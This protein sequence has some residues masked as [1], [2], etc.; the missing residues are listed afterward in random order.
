MEQCT[1]SNTTPLRINVS[2]GDRIPSRDAASSFGNAIALSKDGLRLVVGAPYA[3]NSRG[4]LNGVVRVYERTGNNWTQVGSDL[5][6]ETSIDWLGS[7]V[8]I[9]D[10]GELVIASAP[11]SS[12]KRGYVK[13]W[14]QD[15]SDWKQFGSDI[16]NESKPAFSSDRFGH[17]IS[18]SR[19][20]LSAE[21]GEW[22]YRVA[23]GCPWKI[24]ENMRDSGMALVYEH[25]GYQWNLLGSPLTSVGSSLEVGNSVDLQGNILA[26]GIPGFSGSGAVALYQFVDGN[27]EKGPDTILGTT[28]NARLGKSVASSRR[29]E[30]NDEFSLVVGAAS[31]VAIYEMVNN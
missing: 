3:S 8:D 29:I 18:V 4:I 1:H 19:S 5:D 24:V 14:I 10:D 9:S 12:S 23:I 31:S 27:W 28:A 22:R 15:G 7:S 25:D 30:G 17:S 13:A 21:D 26:V 16:I 6:G 2:F 20:S 11:R